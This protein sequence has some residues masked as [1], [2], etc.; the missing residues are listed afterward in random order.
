M[1]KVEEGREGNEEDG[2]EGM[3]WMREGEGGSEGNGR[4][5]WKSKMW[6]EAE[7]GRGKGKV[8]EGDGVGEWGMD[9]RGGR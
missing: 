3:G 4:T 6:M 9:E 5:G 7:E 2:V 8:G 1:G